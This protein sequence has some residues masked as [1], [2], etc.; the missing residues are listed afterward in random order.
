MPCGNNLKH[1]YRVSSGNKRDKSRLLCSKRAS[2]D[3][4]FRNTFLPKV[5]FVM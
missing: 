1:E 2:I 4:E 5:Y 3:T